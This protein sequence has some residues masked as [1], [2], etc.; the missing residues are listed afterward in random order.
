MRES[1]IRSTRARYFYEML[2]IFR[3]G[4]ISRQES[5]RAR[6]YGF[7]TEMQISVVEY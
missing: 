4:G 3:D 7:I 2:G 6:N 1:L 5:E